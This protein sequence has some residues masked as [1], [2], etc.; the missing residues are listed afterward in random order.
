MAD[1]A[2]PAPA[3]AS[4]PAPTPVPTPTP[5]PDAAASPDA[6]PAPAPDASARRPPSDPAAEAG[7]QRL[8]FSHDLVSGRYRGAVHFG[9]VRL[10][11]GEDSDSD[12][13]DD[14]RASSGCSEAGGAGHED[15]RAS[16]LRRGYVRVQW[17]PEGVKQHVKETKVPRGAGARVRVAPLQP[18]CSRSRSPGRP[19][20][21]SS[22]TA[23][24]AVATGPSP[25]GGPGRALLHPLA[26]AASP[27]GLAGLPGS[28]C[29]P[30]PCLLHPA[31]A[32]PGH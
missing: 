28:F 16:P 11:H 7:S 6:T 17:Y 4:A 10:I 30:P 1:P 31:A 20:A 18:R 14:G 26:P 13:D 21:E 19:A 29:K 24:A 23:A 27:R 32:T 3:P 15:G 25:G 5:A 2:A 8:L 12:A 22:S 9:L